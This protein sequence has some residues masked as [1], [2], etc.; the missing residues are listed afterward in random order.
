MYEDITRTIKKFVLDNFVYW[1]G[2]DSVSET[3]SLL[4]NGIID[5]AGI[6]EL[7]T[8]LESEFGITVHDEEV[9][10]RN[11]DSVALAAAFVARKLQESGQPASHAGILVEQTA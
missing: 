10:P 9:L 4:G 1:G 8:F 6:L 3:D 11:L 5:S 7:I 2:A